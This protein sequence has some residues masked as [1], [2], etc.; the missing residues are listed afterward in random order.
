[1]FGS[2]KKKPKSLL[3]P[4]IYDH[5]LED[6]RYWFVNEL[7]NIPPKIIDGKQSN[8][9]LNF[10]TFDLHTLETTDG[11]AHMR[12]LLL[13]ESTEQTVMIR[14]KNLVCDLY[15]KYGDDLIDE[16]RH[17]VYTTM[18][19]VYG[20]TFDVENMLDAN[21][22]LWLHPFIIRIYSELKMQK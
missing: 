7:T 8:A 10:A 18:T 4:E 3:T 17:R 21:N 11:F 6:I 1:M 5:I 20:L 13:G 19:N 2:L 12:L 14:L 16:L 9:L 15:I 22:T